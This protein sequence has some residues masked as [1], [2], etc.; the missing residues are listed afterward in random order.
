MKRNIA[1]LVSLIFLSL[2]FFGC[3]TVEVKKPPL[4]SCERDNI[5]LTKD[6]PKNIESLQGE[7]KALFSPSKLAI[8]F[9]ESFVK[10][11]LS[12]SQE[13]SG[14]FLTSTVV[15]PKKARDKTIKYIKK[16]AFL[17]IANLL[18]AS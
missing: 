15:Q 10:I 8:L 14:G 9:G 7:K 2:V 16:A 4:F 1:F 6:A 3:T 5:I 11:I 18:P 12:L 13:K 17:F